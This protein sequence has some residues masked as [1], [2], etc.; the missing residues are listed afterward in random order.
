VRACLAAVVML[1]A[2]VP[3]CSRA[4]APVPG[5]E[6]VLWRSPQ[7]EPRFP[8]PPDAAWVPVYERLRMA[9]AREAGVDDRWACYRGGSLD[10]V[11]AF[12]APL[13]GVDPAAVRVSEEPAARF[14]ATVRSVSDH[15]GH[16]VPADPNQGG[17]V[18]RVVLAQRR[19]LPMLLLESPFPNPAR[20][21]ADRG[22]L[23]SMR[24]RQPAPRRRRRSSSRSCRWRRWWCR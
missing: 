5:G 21:R 11:L 15:L 14:F 23:I 22:T 13:Y 19:D 6:V 18:R 9:M 2:T 16:A 20:G 12:Y 7:P 17:V 3:G 4:P 1:L 10:D 8:V 24:W